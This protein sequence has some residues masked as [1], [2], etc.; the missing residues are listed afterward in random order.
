MDIKVNTDG[1]VECVESTTIIDST[2]EE[3]NQIKDQLGEYDKSIPRA[4]EDLIAFQMQSGYQ[5]FQSQLDIIAAKQALR[6][7]LGVLEGT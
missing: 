3:I 1:T 2:A 4:L 6:D 5:P 7:R